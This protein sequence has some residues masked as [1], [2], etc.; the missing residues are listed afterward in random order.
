[1]NTQNYGLV[2]DSRQ[3]VAMIYYKNKTKSY[4]IPTNDLNIYTTKGKKTQE[5]DKD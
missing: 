3:L 5:T 1:M 2:W 4:M